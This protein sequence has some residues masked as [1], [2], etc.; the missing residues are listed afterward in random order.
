MGL[1]EK[2]Q[3]TSA[4]KGHDKML[5]LLLIIINIQ[6]NL[7]LLQL[8]G[9]RQ[10]KWLGEQHCLGS[11]AKISAVF[12]GGQPLPYVSLIG[13]T[14]F[15]AIAFPFEH[16]VSRLF[17]VFF[18]YLKKMNTLTYLISRTMYIISVF[19]FPLRLLE[20]FQMWGRVYWTSE[21]KFK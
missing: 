5:V 10:W 13:N 18:K 9:N 21:M 7:H 20:E 16:F 8:S 14:Y 19:I 4:C 2:I 12:C 3:W 1:W 17:G 11:Q 15:T 6:H